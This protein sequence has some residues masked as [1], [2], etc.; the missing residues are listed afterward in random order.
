MFKKNGSKKFDIKDTE[1]W[2]NN[3]CFTRVRVATVVGN[4]RLNP[5]HTD[6]SYWAP[7][8]H[9][10]F[11]RRPRSPPGSQVLKHEC[12]DEL[13]GDPAYHRS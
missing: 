12:P 5:S 6:G 11:K 9:S 2:M 3:K 8:A 7:V 4:D 13:E 10:S 1:G